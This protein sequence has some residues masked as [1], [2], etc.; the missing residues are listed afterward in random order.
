[1]NSRKES[2]MYGLLRLMRLAWIILSESIMHPTEMSLVTFDSGGHVHIERSPVPSE[3][4]NPGD[5]GDAVPFE[6]K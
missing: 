4:G 1:M 3:D 2:H 5:G 6:E